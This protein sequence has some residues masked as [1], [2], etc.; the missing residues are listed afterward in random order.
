MTDST[1][2]PPPSEPPQVPPP[3]PPLRQRGGWATAF[4]V[5]VGVILLLPGL[6]AIIF[7]GSM[8]SDGHPDSAIIT[9]V[10]FGLAL[11]LGGV[12]LIHAAIRGPRP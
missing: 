3:G 8:L 1:T 11:G 10:F 6:C 4:M 2:P 9:L 5:I 12:L 7:G